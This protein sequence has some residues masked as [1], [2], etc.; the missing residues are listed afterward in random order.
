[1]TSPICSFS[2]T[3]DEIFFSPLNESPSSNFPVV[4]PVAPLSV[5]TSLS[6]RAL[7]GDQGL[8][9]DSF[10][11]IL[12]FT[13]EGWL[14]QS[15]FKEQKFDDLSQLIQSFPKTEAYPITE[16]DLSELDDFCM[17]D[18]IALVKRCGNLRVVNLS[19]VQH[20]Q[21]N[22]LLQAIAN[23]CP[24]L[25]K[26]DLEGCCRVE[27]TFL[28]MI[29]KNCFQLKHL[30]VSYC[31]LLSGRFLSSLTQFAR[32]LEVFCVNRDPQKDGRKKGP[33]LGNQGRG[34]I[35]FL[36]KHP[37]LIELNLAGQ[38][39]EALGGEDRKETSAVS[40][41][42]ILEACPYLQTLDLSQ[43]D[44]A[45]GSFSTIGQKGSSLR[46]LVWDGGNFDEI[47]DED[48]VALSKGCRS[49]EVLN[50]FGE[51]G[52]ITDRSIEFLVENCPHLTELMIE[53]IVQVTNQSLQAIQKHSQKLE[54]LRLKQV[55]SADRKDE[56]DEESMVAFLQGMGDSFRNFGLENFARISPALF[57]KVPERFSIWQTFSLWNCGSQAD[58]EDLSKAVLQKIT[59]FCPEITVLE[60]VDCPQMQFNI[61]FMCQLFRN[62]ENLSQLVLEPFL[63]DEKRVYRLEYKKPLNHR[64]VDLKINGKK[65]VITYEM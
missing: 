58:K 34:L 56:I 15:A 36:K 10:K 59:Q 22:L 57:L 28:E 21:L 9:N 31:E 45:K 29:L 43:C 23:S 8:G 41:D 38:T 4:V 60:F 26:L 33:F 16:L 51:K 2:K 37:L 30:D 55:A 49:L 13:G 6:Q 12:A 64:L 1:M 7:Y 54:L 62:C 46:V 27:D 44:W 52:K 53:G 42:V 25:E 24:L 17:S 63:Y 35:D 14:Y 32:N 61:D 47:T 40:V 18:V 65:I 19:Q 48:V 39:K 20:F 11:A 50:V 3:Q 5:V